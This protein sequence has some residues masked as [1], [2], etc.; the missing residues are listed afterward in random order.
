VTLCV[1]TE[2]VAN[3]SELAHDVSRGE[4]GFPSMG[5]DEVR[6]LDRHGVTI[7]SH[8]RTHY[9]CGTSDFARLEE[10]IAGS[11]RELEA[12]LGHPVRT[13]AFPKGKPQNI[14]PLACAVALRH[15]PVVMSAAGGP[16]VGPIALPAELRRHSHPDSL[17]EL[18]MQLQEILDP[19]VPLR[20]VEATPALAMRAPA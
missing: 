8:T 19:A 5:W 10:E 14:S 6:Y 20:P 13:F 3:R 9:N 18:E 11:A 4:R 17:L 16:N 7:A 1:C 15:Y 2:H 12:A